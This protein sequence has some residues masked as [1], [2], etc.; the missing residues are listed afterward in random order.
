[1]GDLR[2]L[3]DRERLVVSYE[4]AVADAVAALGEFERS[5]RRAHAALDRVD[6]VRDAVRR[7]PLPPQPAEQAPPSPQGGHQGPGCSSE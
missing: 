4:Q 2:R 1:M 3:A 5:L 6:S 7:D